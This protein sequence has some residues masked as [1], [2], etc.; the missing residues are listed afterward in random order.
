M[1]DLVYN[2]T[3]VNW[4]TVG[5]WKATS[6]MPGYQNSLKQFLMDKGA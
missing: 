4:D 2:G 6:G 5:H 3:S 1:A